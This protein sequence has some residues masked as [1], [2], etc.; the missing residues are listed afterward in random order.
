MSSNLGHGRPQHGR[1]SGT[2]APSPRDVVSGLRDLLTT[3]TGLGQ[4]HGDIR[5]AIL[6]LL[7]EEP[8]HGSQIIGQIAE[9]SHGVWRPGAGAVYPTLQQLADE[10]LVESEEVDGRKVH[11]LTEE[12]RRQAEAFTD[13]PAPWQTA[14][15]ENAAHTVA[16][17][18]AG[19]KLAQAIGQVA[20]A[21]SPEQVSAAVE[22]VDEARRKLYAILAE[23]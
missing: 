1:R 11:H 4:G 10:G 16:L 14:A 19:A 7:A 3:T 18:K 15:V 6:V 20:R 21:G 23:H 22:V 5:A 13:R 8:M 9:R 12:G 17:P 2:W